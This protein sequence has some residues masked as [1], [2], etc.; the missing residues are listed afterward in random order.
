MPTL[1]KS[2]AG[3]SSGIVDDESRIHIVVLLYHEEVYE[4]FPNFLCSQ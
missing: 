4:C 2:K 1:A 3:S